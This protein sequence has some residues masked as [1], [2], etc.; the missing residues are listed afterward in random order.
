MIAGRDAGVVAIGVATGA[1][2]ADALLRAGAA[3]T[4]DSLIAFPNLY[5]ALD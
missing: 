2:T 4:L 1:F 5:A 3:M